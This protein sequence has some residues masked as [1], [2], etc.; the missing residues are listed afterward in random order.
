MENVILDTAPSAEDAEAIGIAAQQAE[1]ADVGA[2]DP[3]F[4]EVDT[5][6]DGGIIYVRED[7]CAELVEIYKGYKDHPKRQEIERIWKMIYRMYMGYKGPGVEYS[8]R[9]VFRQIETLEPAIM[10]QL[11]GSDPLFNLTSHA[12]GGEDAAA[13]AQHLMHYQLKNCDSGRSLRAMEMWVS[14]AV[15][16]GTAYATYG[17]QT[18]RHKQ[19]KRQHSHDVDTGKNVWDKTS[20]EKLVEAPYV[21]CLYPWDVYCDPYCEDAKQ[22]PVAFARKKVSVGFL[23]TLVREGYLDAEAV[24]EAVKSEPTGPVL[25][26]NHPD[27]RRTDVGTCTDG[28]SVHEML[29]A[30]TNDGWEYVII[31][32]T[33]MVRGRR[34]WQSEMPLVTLRNYPQPGEHFGIPEPLIIADEQ[35]LLNDMTTLYVKGYHYT[36]MPMFKVKRGKKKDLQNT[37]FQPGGFMEVDDPMDV[38]PFDANPTVLSMPEHIGFIRNNMQMGTGVTGELAGTGSSAKTATAHVRLQDAAGE[39]IKHKVRLFGPHLRELYKCLY[40]L[41]QANLEEEQL[42]RMVGPEGKP[43]LKKYSPQDFDQYVDV[44][45][46]LGNMGET[47]MEKVQK[48][49][50]AYQM[51][52]QDPLVDRQPILDAIFRGLGFKRPMMLRASPV[53]GKDDQLYEISQ[54]QIGQVMPEVRAADDHQTHLQVLQMFMQSPTFLNANEAVKFSTISH[55]NMHMA[56]YQKMMMAQQ[57]AAQSQTMMMGGPENAVAGEANARTEAEFNNAQAGASQQGQVIQ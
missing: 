48:M 12:E 14:V 18:Y 23:K 29:I 19:Y 38:V 36:M 45:I 43:I 42:L 53:N 15:K 31:D 41:N 3:E 21:E 5:A 34:L 11:L 56:Y 35:K 24:E 1:E 13:A 32:E 17:W 22:S 52:G 10:G 26:D 30:W 37:K 20:E 27:D 49:M 9:E 16:Y 33:T 2:F 39:R 25:Q 51:V 4:P 47:S 54:L 44:D 7:T 55:F 46:D 6:E 40:Q 8:I 57:Q 28:T 50:Q